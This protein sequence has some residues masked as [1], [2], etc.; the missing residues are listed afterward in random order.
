M[1]ITAD[2][3]LAAL[4]EAVEE[5]GRDYVYPT[6]LMETCHYRWTPTDVNHGN[7]Y[8][9]KPACGVGVALDK[10]GVLA[11]VVP[12]WA[13]PRNSATVTKLPFADGVITPGAIAVLRAFQ[14]SQDRAM[15]WGTALRRAE[16]SLSYGIHD[17]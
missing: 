13:T 1:T 9:N 17:R 8:L 11:D 6:T 7:G 16:E 5:R 3:A 15:F 2:M 14:Y 10:L 4:R 12:N